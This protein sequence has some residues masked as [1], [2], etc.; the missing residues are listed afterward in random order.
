MDCKGECCCAK[1]HHTISD[2]PAP[3]QAAAPQPKEIPTGPCVS[4]AP[5]G[6]EGV[7]PGDTVVPAYKVGTLGHAVHLPE[8]H[9][10]ERLSRKRAEMPANPPAAQIEEPPERR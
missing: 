6:R 2:P 10:G 5:C 9:Y 4:A 3:S 7:P 8:P 1:K